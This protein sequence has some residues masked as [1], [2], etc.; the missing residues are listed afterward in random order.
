MA[1]GVEVGAVGSERLKGKDAAG[2]YIFSV[3]Q[4]LKAFYY[5]GISGLG[6]QAEQ[7]ALA[8]EQAAQYARDRK[9][10]VTVGYGGEDLAGKFFGEQNGAFGLAAGAEIVFVRFESPCAL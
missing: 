10:P 4:G 5:R 6:Q 3:E 2:A 7:T 9:G 8:L 1:M